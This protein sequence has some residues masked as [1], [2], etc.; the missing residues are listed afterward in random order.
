MAG[1]LIWNESS[2]WKKKEQAIFLLRLAELLKSGYHLSE[3]LAFLHSQEKG[4]R[5]ENIVQAIDMLAAGHSLYEALTFLKF[6]S[7]LLQYVYYA[8]HYGDLSQALQEGGDFWRKRNED[9]DKLLKILLYPI[10]LLILIVAIGFLMQGLLLPKFESLHKDLN[11][12]PSLFLQVVLLLST[13][14]RYIPHFLV[15]L[16]LCLFCWKVFYYNKLPFLIRKKLI[17]RIP[18][19]NQFIR[20]FDTYYFSYQ[21]SS[22][23]KGG[24]SIN[25]SMYLFSEQSEKL[26]YK[27]L[28]KQIYQ[29]L[30]DGN[31]LEQAFSHLPFFEEFFS[32]IVANG[33]KNGKLDQELYHYSRIILTMI[34]DKMTALVR[35]VQP[36]LFAFI[37]FIVVAIYL[38]VLLPMFSVIE[39][40]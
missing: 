12:A 16:I 7:Q 37:G 2:K 25:E 21:L 38:S 24:L 31:S 35:L 4:K 13:S 32:E 9:Q 8:E 23:L 30:N 3:A 18:L 40:M 20:M 22:L 28:G 33:Q 1:G 36:L 10:M 39:G 17:L 26:F 6:N 15:I 27:E 34:E 19:I 11:L 14:S 29:K 5:K